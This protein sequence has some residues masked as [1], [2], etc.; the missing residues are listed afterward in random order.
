[1]ATSQLALYN[2]ALTMYLGERKLASL[3]ENRE[4]RRVLDDVWSQGAVKYCLEQGHWKFAQRSAKLSYSPDFTPSFGY[5]R[6]FEKPTDLVKVSKL[7]SD[8][9]LNQPIMAYSDEAGFWAT[10]FD[11]I[12]IS[13]VSSHADFGSDMGLWPE[14]FIRYV[15]GYLALRACNRI[16]QSGTDTD[17]LKKD[18]ENLLK[19]ARSKDAIQGP[20]VFPPVG[21]WIAARRGDFSVLDR[22]P[23]SSLYG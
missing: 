3:S 22:R 4:P 21:R 17:A 20:T 18:V 15:A 6:I 12:Y 11:D 19:D 9:W 8:E 1:M 13:Y 2:E 10:D 5:R 16:K 23:R 7:C 14:S